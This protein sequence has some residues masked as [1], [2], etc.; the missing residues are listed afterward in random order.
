MVISMLKKNYFP[1]LGALLLV[2]SLSAAK[3]EP[4]GAGISLRDSPVISRDATLLRIRDTRTSAAG[5]GGGGGGSDNTCWSSCF[6]NYNGCMETGPKNMC[7]TRVKSCLE[8][9]DR[10]SNKPRM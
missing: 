8:L 1:I 10:L 6:K 9:C 4:V 3:A 7:V 5:G 2:A